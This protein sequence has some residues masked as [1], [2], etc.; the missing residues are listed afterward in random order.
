M[1]A[2][3]RATTAAMVAALSLLACSCGGGGD[4]VCILGYKAGPPFDRTI[5]TVRVPIFQNETFIRGIEFQL[6]ELVDKEI[7]KRTPWKVVGCEQDAD[8][9]LTGVVTAYAKRLLVPSQ[10]NEIRQGEI[11]LG[12]YIVWRDLRTGQVLTR[13]PGL[14]PP[15]LPGEPPP[16]GLVP[17]MRG[18]PPVAGLPPVSPNV[19]L[20]P[21][22]LPGHRD[23][24]PLEDRVLIQRTVPFVPELGQSTA[25]ARLQVCEDL[26]RQI[27]NSM[28]LPW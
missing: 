21:G 28:E 3:Y 8:T 1:T 16:E 2:P 18:A 15:P 11:T 27:V 17:P 6:T 10:L 20:P 13:A 4:G 12:V 26:A 9:E 19:A 23:I 14:P 7:E 22:L 24:I 25:T 5:R